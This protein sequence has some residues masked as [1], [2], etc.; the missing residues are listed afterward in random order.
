M[1]TPEVRL[2]KYKKNLVTSGWGVIVFCVWDIVKYISTFFIKSSYSEYL[3]EFLPGD[4]KALYAFAMF[5]TLIIL[6]L[7]LFLHAFV[8]KCAIQVGQ[9]KRHRLNYI[10][11]AIILVLMTLFSFVTGIVEINSMPLDLSIASLI[12]DSTMLVALMDLLISSFK[13]RSL[14]KQ[15]AAKGGV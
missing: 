6:G 12:L 9:G 14:E 10:P 7:I 13:V 11:V 1:K 8:G 2:R 15:T 3:E 4:D 5:F